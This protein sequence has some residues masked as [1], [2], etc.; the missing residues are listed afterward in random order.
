MPEMVE[1]ESNKGVNI[2]W[3]GVLVEI[4]L[5]LLGLL[6]GWLGFYD[7]Q[8]PINSIQWLTWSDAIPWGLI[9]LL[10]MLGYLILF[11]FWTPEFYRPMQRVMDSQLR[12]MF[13]NYS[14]LELLILSIFA[15]F[16]E[17]LFFRWCLQG[18]VTSLLE[19]T[20][21]TTISIGAGIAIASL[22]FGVCHWVNKT[23]AITTT[24]VGAYLGATM[25]LAGT[26]LVPAIAH[27]AF[28][29]VA[30][31]YIVNSR[32]KVTMDV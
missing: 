4:G 24:I 6:L 20:V 8:Q 28:D 3:I 16:G 25:V 10:P 22:I 9:A 26:W 29:F 14:Y 27:S 31:I 5:C 21:G 32:P 19:P 17:E 30:L 11:H 15:G 18:G 1:S 13:S 12:P 23:Y 2:V 7:H